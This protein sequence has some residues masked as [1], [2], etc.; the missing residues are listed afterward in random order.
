M[1]LTSLGHEVVRYARARHGSVEAAL[2]EFQ[3]WYRSSKRF[4]DLAPGWGS[5]LVASSSSIRRR[6]Y[7]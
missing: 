4:V 6:S 7:S 3:E 5:L 2:E 1:E